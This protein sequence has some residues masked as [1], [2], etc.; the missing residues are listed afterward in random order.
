MNQAALKTPSH[1]ILL[2]VSTIA[3]GWLSIIGCF[4][5]CAIKGINPPTELFGALK[6]ISLFAGG[7]IVSFL[8]NLRSAEVKTNGDSANINQD[9]LSS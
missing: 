1:L 3:F 9:T 5:F 2:I 4:I 6:D 7:A 8:T